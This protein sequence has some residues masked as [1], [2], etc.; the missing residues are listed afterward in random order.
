MKIIDSHA[1]LNFKAFDEDRIEVAKN[2]IKGGV[3]MINVGSQYETSK[4]AVD[5]AESFKEGVYASV[6]LHPI[7][8]IADLVKI[9]KDPEEEEEGES[10][11]N[12]GAY[13]SL[14]TSSKVVAIGEAG[15]DYYYKPKNKGKLEKFKDRQKLVFL[16]HIRLAE[17]FGLPMIIHC[18]LAHKEMTELLKGCNGTI[19]GVI[20]CFTGDLKDAKDYLDMG[21]YLGF[22]GIIFKLDL[23]DIIKYVPAERILAET[24][25]PYLT[26]PSRSGRNEPLY[27]KDVIAEIARL[28]KTNFDRMA[29]ITAENAKIL[30]EI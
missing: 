30:F 9:K 28:R 14:A 6:G 18:R 19:G 13:K 15:L 27:V 10:D 22:T 17:K 11:F 2:S 23:K 20:H 1:H 25:C 26:P 5:M 3:W 16:K 7:H 8:I 29:E 21:F 4:K 12:Y 24:D